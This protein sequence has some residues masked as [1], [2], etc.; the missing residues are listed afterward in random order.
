MSTSVKKQYLI[1]PSWGDLQRVGP[2][3]L[4]LLH[5]PWMVPCRGKL[6]SSATFLIF[7]EK[8][9]FL[10]IP[11]QSSQWLHLIIV[12]KNTSSQLSS[13]QKGRSKKKTFPH[14]G[15]SNKSVLWFLPIGN[16][17]E[18]QDFSWIKTTRMFLTESS[19]SQ[20]EVIRFMSGECL[21]SEDRG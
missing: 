1:Y 11:I 19:L 10:L 18:S 14:V 20:K 6:F 5:E 15:V 4:I 3:H 9:F 16:L 2:C 7:E 13:V 21:L 12:F 8:T 17:S